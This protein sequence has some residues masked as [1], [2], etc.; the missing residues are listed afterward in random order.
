MEAAVPISCTIMEIPLLC[1]AAAFAGAWGAPRRSISPLS[2]ICIPA[3]MEDNVDFPEPFSPI[4]PWTS[5]RLSVKST[6][7][8]A[9]VGPK[10]LLIP[11]A[12]RI[13]SVI[14]LITAPSSL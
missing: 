6:F 5:P 10:F 3:M 4:S 2:G 9:L 7:A 14:L 11:R 8:S 13:V 1:A 12:S